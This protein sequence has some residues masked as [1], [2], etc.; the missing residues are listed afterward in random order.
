MADEPKKYRG[1]Y[2]KPE[3]DTGRIEPDRQPARPSKDMGSVYDKVPLSTGSMSSR[4][5]KAAKSAEKTG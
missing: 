1:P 3:K 4:G 5:R 2:I